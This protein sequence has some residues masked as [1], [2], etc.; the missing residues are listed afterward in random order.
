MEKRRILKNA[1]KG[2]LT[3]LPIAAAA[4]AVAYLMAHK[5]GPTKRRD[6]EAVRTLRVISAPVVDFVPRAVGY[7]VAAPGAVWEAVAEVSGT[8]AAI[9]PRLKSGELIEAGSLL[10]RIDAAEYELAVARLEAGIDEIGANIRQLD[11]EQANIR[12]L[13]DIEQRSLNLARRSLERKRTALERRAIS[14]P[15]LDLCFDAQRAQFALGDQLAISNAQIAANLIRLYKALGGGWE[16]APP[17]PGR[18]ITMDFHIF[19]KLDSSQ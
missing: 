8:V 15:G 17:E 7:G 13:L 16:S 1:L 9:H 2:V 12:Q 10:V 19:L 3:L 6:T 18:E 5:P 11:G 4:L 14:H